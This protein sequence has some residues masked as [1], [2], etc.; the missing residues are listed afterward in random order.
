MRVV[1]FST[2]GRGRA[3]V[4]FSD[5]IPPPVRCPKQTFRVLFEEHFIPNRVNVARVCQYSILRANFL[6]LLQDAHRLFIAQSGLSSI[7]GGR[8]PPSLSASLSRREAAKTDFNDWESLHRK[9][10]KINGLRDGINCNVRPGCEETSNNFLRC[11]ALC[12]QS[13][14]RHSRSA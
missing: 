1:R 2:S 14:S 13:F 3:C 10:F 4:T 5:R 6:Y 8:C 11:K 9:S 12:P 7:P